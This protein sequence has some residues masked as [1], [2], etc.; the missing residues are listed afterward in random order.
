[1]KPTHVSAVVE[2]FLPGGFARDYEWTSRSLGMTHY[3]IWN[4]TSFT[5]PHEPS[6][7]DYPDGF[8]GPN[9][10]VHGPFVAKLIEGHVTAREQ[11]VPPV[12]ISPLYDVH[13]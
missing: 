3:S 6:I 5:H 4:D 9:I 7:P 13:R 8:H 12:E 2:I 10:P 11:G 1:M